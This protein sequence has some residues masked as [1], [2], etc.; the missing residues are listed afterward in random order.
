MRKLLGLF[1]ILTFCL[2]AGFAQ[3]REITGIAVNESDGTPAIGVMVVVSG[4]QTAAITDGNGRFT[5]NA[6]PNATLSFSSLGFIPQDV[7]L[8]GRTNINVSMVTDTQ[9]IEDV[10]VVGYGTQ[11]KAHLTGA[12]AAISG[13]EIASKPSTDVLSALQGKLPGVAVLRTSGQP[14]QETSGNGG[15]RIRG[16]SSSNDASALILIDGVEGSLTM[17]NPDDIE[18]ISV[19]KDAASAA[20]YGS[21]AAA[22]VVLVTTKKGTD[23]QRLQLSYNGSFGFNVPGA[24]P[25]R[26]PSWEEQDFINQARA[27]DR[28][29]TVEQNPEV[30]SWVGNPNYNY[31]P[32]GA[33]WTQHGNTNWLKEG[34]R[35]FS[36]QQSHALT[37]SGGHGKTNYFLSG[38]FYTKGGMLKYGPNNFDRYNLR[39]TVNTEMNKYLSLDVRMS[40]EGT[41]RKEPTYNAASLLG[42]MYNARGRQAVYLPEEDTNYESNPYS[43]DLQQNP[44]EAMKEGGKVTYNQQY[45]TGNASLH[46]KNVVKGLTLDLNISRKAGVYAAEG[47]YIYRPS[48]GRNGALRAGYDLNN[49]GRVSKT[50]N[51]SYQDKLEALLNYDLQL[52]DHHF[53]LLGGASY[54]QYLKDEMTAEA[55]NLLSAETFSFNFYNSDL[56]ANSILSDA[57]QPWKMASLFGRIN[58]DFA[59]RYLFEAVL[60]YDGSSRLAPGNRWGTFPSFSGAWRVSEEAF[61]ENIRP[62]VNN[63]KLRA[64][65][66]QLG[67]S[68]VLNSMYYPYI[69]TISNKTE[70]STTSIL[71]IMG[72]PVYYQKDMVSS[73]VSWETVQT[74]NIGLDMTLFG[75]KLDLTADYYWKK[76]NDMLA[77]LRVGNIAGVVNLPYQNVGVLKSWGWEIS[78]QWRDKI[79]EFSYQIGASIEDSQNRLIRYDGNNVIRAGMVRLLEGY[80]M[81]TIWGYRTDGFWNSREEYL[82]YKEA[83][84]GYMTLLN[85]A[86]I[87]GGDTRYLTQGKA[88]HQVGIGGGTPEDPGDLVNLG[89]TD[90]RYL[91]GINLA[92][93]WKGIDFSMFWQGV[94]KRNF[95]VSPVHLAPMGES[96]RMPLSIHRDHWR[97]DN[98]DAYFARP[99]E[100]G[101]AFNY[102]TADRWVQNGAYLRL[103][104][105]QLGYTIPI[106]KNVIQSLRVYVQGTDV[107]EFTKCLEIYDPEVGPR[108]SDTDVTNQYYP[109]FRTWTLGVNLT[110]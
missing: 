78:A 77:K 64:S 86:K 79:G 7:A 50:K 87:A 109:F 67:N 38:G 83:N 33:R 62:Y 99:Y 39:A 73:D 48:M 97:E 20:I 9:M 46:V 76:N 3:Q 44:I 72:N 90:V 60:R 37:L 4:T 74:T 65:W 18:S 13:D 25:Q 32:N 59:G 52:G 41:V 12:V 29:G 1:A 5:I 49:P 6:D 26:M 15:L 36:T 16:F 96:Q 66:G 93:Q 56:A 89:T 80:P 2:H 103:K 85:D 100:G 22:G 10:V 70:T 23:S 91:Y 24:M 27:A 104:N 8:A 53:H 95:L 19:L 21:R 94:G 84:P 43:A 102:Q 71:S 106:R 11:R 45:F 35:N 105:V 82:A 34:T 31:Y 68:T 14:G 69:G 42:I 30:T 51:S 28:N 92:A 110:F 108:G 40:Y 75:G 107:L 101:S 55:R 17:L 63:L 98:K 81:N 61:W 58:Y 57:I 54:E 47:D 88:D